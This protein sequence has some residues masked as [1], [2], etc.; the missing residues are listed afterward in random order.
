MALVRS[1]KLPDLMKDEAIIAVT[2]TLRDL[3]V[4][5]SGS[6]GD[7]IWD[8]LLSVGCSAAPWEVDCFRLGG[9]FSTKLPD[10]IKDAAVGSLRELICSK[11]SFWEDADLLLDAA[12][13]TV[14]PLLLLGDVGAERCKDALREIGGVRLGLEDGANDA[15]S[16]ETYDLCEVDG[17]LMEI[18]GDP[19]GVAFNNKVE[20][21]RE[22]TLAVLDKDVEW[23]EELAALVVV[24]WSN[25]I[26]L[27]V[28]NWCNVDLL[29][30]AKEAPLRALYLLF[31]VSIEDARENLLILC[32]IDAASEA[33]AVDEDVVSSL[34]DSK[35]KVLTDEATSDALREGWTDVVGDADAGPDSKRKDITGDGDGAV[36]VKDILLID[37]EGTLEEGVLLLLGEEGQGA[38]GVS[39]TPR[40]AIRSCSLNTIQSWWISYDCECEWGRGGQ[41]GSD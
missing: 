27:V 30:A 29:E 32:D 19:K 39:D 35:E 1:T 37:L 34:E 20:F 5:V 28:A 24:N 13:D 15:S 41:L 14:D 23:A 36:G 3:V 12:G 18:A 7:A 11:D 16:E 33:P 6:P 8:C 26:L 25:V 38:V 17:L 31:F 40:D 22:D 2:G 9:G 10:R 21:V 4:A